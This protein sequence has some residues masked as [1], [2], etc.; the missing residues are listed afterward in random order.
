MCDDMHI[1]LTIASRARLAVAL[2]ALAGCTSNPSPSEPA[3]STDDGTTS[4][5]SGTD[6]TTDD[7]A[8]TDDTASPTGSTSPGKGT[9]VDAGKRSDAGASDA[10]AAKDAGGAVADAGLTG[11]DS[12]LVSDAQDASAPVADAGPTDTGEMDAG[13]TTKDAGDDTKDASSTKDAAS[14]K[15]AA[16]TT[17][18]SSSCSGDTPHGCYVARD[19]NPMGC[20]DQIHEQSQFYP[21]MDEWVACS[22]PYYTACNYAKPDGGD[23]AHCE[24]D[25]GLHWLCTY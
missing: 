11:L 5:S 2:L 10:G 14:P 18:P 8:T 21:P 25:L 20:P 9:N 19:N 1:N 16:T 4:D 12:G 23:D 15:D 22:S 3:P 6:G 17:D 13:V 24:C 7:V